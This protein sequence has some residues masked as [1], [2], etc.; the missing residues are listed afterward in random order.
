[1]LLLDPSVEGPCFLGLAAHAAPLQVLTQ[2]LEQDLSPGQS[3]VGALEAN[4]RSS[5]LGHLRGAETINVCH[6]TKSVR[7]EK[8]PRTV[9]EGA[10]MIFLIVIATR[11]H[12]E[13]QLI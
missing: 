7:F 8:M 3:N 11:I 5:A 10:S 9:G 6:K 2:Q 13:L 4:M 1:L 12:G